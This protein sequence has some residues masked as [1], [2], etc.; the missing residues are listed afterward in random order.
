ML[1]LTRGTPPG[2]RTLLLGIRPTRNQNL[3]RDRQPIKPIKSLSRSAILKDLTWCH[4]PR[5]VVTKRDLL[6]SLSWSRSLLPTRIK[7]NG[8]QS[9]TSSKLKTEL[10]KH[11]SRTLCKPSRVW[12]RRSVGLQSKKKLRNL[13]SVNLDHQG[14]SNFAYRSI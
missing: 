9:T 2:L 3:I 6:V 13:C 11:P 7:D 5:Q 10:Q 1:S 8:N 12:R 4:L 14:S